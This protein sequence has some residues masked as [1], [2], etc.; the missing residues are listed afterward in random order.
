M[1]LIALK[2]AAAQHLESGLCRKIRNPQLRSMHA[3]GTLED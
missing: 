1:P 3:K 2:N